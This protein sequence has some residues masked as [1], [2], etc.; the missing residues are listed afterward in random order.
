MA[1]A[2]RRRL[3][4][5][6]RLG[7]QAR[8][9]AAFALGALALST[10]LAVVTYGLVREILVRQ[11]EGTA[12]T[13]TYLNAK[14]LRDNLRSAGVDE[15]MLL[16]QLQNPAGGSP[17]LYRSGTW[18]GGVQRGT[19]DLPTRLQDM[20]L[21]G[22]PARMRYRLDGQTQLAV[23][24][25]IPAV[26]ASYFEIIPL[27]ELE[28]TLRSLS[29]S[30]LA[31]AVVTTLA[32]AALGASASRRVLRPLAHVSAAAVAIARGRL[33]T[34]VA[35]ADEADLGT[36]VTS[37]NRMASAL[38]ERIEREARFTSD[39]SH[40]LRSPLTTLSASVEVLQGRRGEMPDRARAA[41]DLL[42]AEV[43]RFSA[44]VEDLLEISRFDAGAA[45]LDLE[46]LRISELVI[47]A[48]GAATHD[49]V[50]VVVA[51]DA[52]DCVVQA[53]KRRLTRAIANLVDNAS[54]H[55]GGAAATTVG[56][57][58]SNVR[59]AVEDA[60]PGVADEDRERIFER[61]SRGA[62]TAGRRGAWEGSGLGLS[63][64]RGHVALHGGRV[65]VEDRHG[66]MS[67]ARFVIEL[68][69]VSVT[70]PAQPEP[71]LGPASVPAAD[72]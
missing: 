22:Q 56:L 26:D 69:V 15:Q 49:D 40:E 8:L 38:Q 67:G 64:V 63:L 47:H 33:D 39:V 70:A 2:R 10:L 46:D 35:T 21:G 20:V 41:L 24:V 55:G 61:F 16:D 65:W 57:V 72:A 36:L 29:V 13:E 30:L 32:G 42:A 52:A 5:A 58:G 18:F 37:F 25:P 6:R 44:M 14:L 68:P 50:P 7:L 66:A 17:V 34:R 71:D 28:S 12:T 4:W 60:G 43:S 27:G 62:S 19:D 59:I 31:A 53:D 48:V 45:R 9:T 3:P 51:A 54:R 23:G 1:D 11:R